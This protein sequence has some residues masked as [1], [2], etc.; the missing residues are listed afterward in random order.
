M[1]I[2]KSDTVT[3]NIGCILKCGH[4]KEQ[5]H[6]FT[7]KLTSSSYHLQYLTFRVHGWTIGKGRTHDRV[8]GWRNHN[9]CPCVVP[10]CLLCNCMFHIYTK[11]TR[12]HIYSFNVA[13]IMNNVEQ[14]RLLR[15]HH[16]QSLIAMWHHEPLDDPQSLLP[17]LASSFH[18]IYRNK[19]MIFVFIVHTVLSEV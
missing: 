2:T 9:P 14:K 4:I 1:N 19:A 18:V 8:R 12:L 17:Y 10:S 11:D 15:I 13:K 5:K 16:W 3:S 7:V 6:T